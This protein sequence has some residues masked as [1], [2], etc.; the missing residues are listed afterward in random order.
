ML[1]D[2]LKS[3]S[4]ANAGRLEKRAQM[5]GQKVDLSGQ[6]G[7]TLPHSCFHHLVYKRNDVVH[8]GQSVSPAECTA[9]AI[10]AWASIVD[11]AFPF[12]RLQMG[13]GRQAIV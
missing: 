12:P 4:G 6:R 3:E 13:R 8:K 1:D 9:A 11:A 2:S 5:R 7:H 10:A